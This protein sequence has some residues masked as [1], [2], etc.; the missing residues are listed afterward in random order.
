[1]PEWDWKV[2]AVAAGVVHL[3]WIALAMYVA[4]E[5]GRLLRE[6][7]W[8]GLLLGPLGCLA[9]GMLPVLG[10]ASSSAAAAP[11]DPDLKAEQDAAAAFLRQ[12]PTAGR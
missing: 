3:S 8:F 2:W 10:Q 1:M 6:G 5:R 7:F 4:L 12:V 9:V 11:V